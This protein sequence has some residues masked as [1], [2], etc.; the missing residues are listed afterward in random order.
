MKL[1]G[2]L[3]SVSILAVAAAF[4]PAAGPAPAGAA[5]QARDAPATP[6]KLDYRGVALQ[7]SG[8]AARAEVAIPLV[9]EIAALGADT[10]LL[11]PAATM[12]HARAQAI[13]LDMRRTATPDEVLAVMAECRA[14]K[15]RII[16]MPVVLLSHP[17]GSEWRG[18]IEPPE[19]DDWWRQYRDF[20]KHY[21]D[22]A[23]RGGADVLMVGSELVS[24]EK[25]TSEW[26]ST[27]H[28]ARSIFSGKLSYSA[29]W[30]HYESIKFWDKLDLAAL[31]SYYTLADKKNPTIE[32]VAARW[33]PIREKISAWQRKVGKPIVFTEVGWCSQEGAATAPWNYYQNTRAT[34]EGHEEQRRLYEGFIR[35][36][37]GA[38][39]LSGVIWWEWTTSGGGTGDFDYTPKN[40]PAEQVLRRW[41]D[42][43]RGAGLGA[44]ATGTH[45]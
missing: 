6:W 2:A 28:T 27:I 42:A 8:H 11:S 16:L 17:R 44:A 22:L 18:V 36:W 10:I 45:P 40:K 19:W 35:A 15:L 4:W 41:F 30:D 39:A 25:Y 43:G 13:F 3:A 14:Q 38:P 34:P 32:E 37:S 7:L 12:E 23:A 33:K 31:T 1:L 9:H 24:T 26:I 5:P 29:N 20:I 21:A